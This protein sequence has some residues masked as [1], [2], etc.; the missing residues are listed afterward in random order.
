[1]S[2]RLSEMPT[3]QLHFCQTYFAVRRQS[4][5]LA[6]TWLAILLPLQGIRYTSSLVYVTDT[7]DV[8]T[9][10]LRSLC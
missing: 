1:M 8:M 7:L 5:I 4:L 10:E 6:Y 3:G 2:A 9:K